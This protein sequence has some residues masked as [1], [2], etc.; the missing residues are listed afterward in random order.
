MM[1]RPPPPGRA[2]TTVAVGFLLLDALLLGYGGI[3]WH[4]SGLLVGAGACA[5]FA[6]VVVLVWRRYR[7]ALVD[8]A[9]A[10]R[11]MRDEVRSIR[12]LIEQQRQGG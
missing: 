12:D 2:L 8:I 7:R 5:A 4:R 11:A 10:R 6:V 1:Q 3:A 9:A